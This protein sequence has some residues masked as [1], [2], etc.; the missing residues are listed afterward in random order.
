MKI[1]VIILVVYLIGLLAVGALFSKFNKNT[2]DY[3]RGGAKASWWLGGASMVLASISA[4]TF[5]GNASAAFDA[6][7]SLLVIYAANCSAFLVCALFLGARL[8]Q[9]RAHTVAD[10][11]RERFGTAAEQTT[12]ISGVLLAPFT[13]AVQLW[14]LSLFASVILDLPLTPTILAIGGIVVFY[15]TAGGR[16]AVMAT[17]F[18]QGVLL[19]GV[20]AI[21]FVLALNK[22]GGVDGFLSFFS[23]PRF[24]EDFS[25][26]KEPGAFPDDKFTWHWMVVIFFMQLYFQLGMWG[27][28]RFLSLKDGKEARKASL[29]A[30]TLV[31]FGVIIW[32]LPP[33]VSRFLYESEV[34]ALDV[35]SPSNYSY[36]YIARQ[37]LPNGM[38]GLMVAAMFA[39]TM[40]SMDTGLN[41][42]TGMIARNLLPWICKRFGKTLPVDSIGIRICKIITVILGIEIVALAFALSVQERFPLFD[43]YLMIASLVGIPLGFP[44]LAGLWIKRMPPWSFFLIFAGCLIPSLYSIYDETANGVKWSIQDRSMW[45]FI[46]GIAACIISRILYFTTGEKWRERTEAF[47]AQLRK[48]IDFEKE[49]GGANDDRQALILG[50]VCLAMGLGALSLIAM[51]NPL[52]GRLCFV[53]LSAFMA[54]VGALLIRLS[55]RTKENADLS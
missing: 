41:N 27:A 52:W 18:A 12:V 2:S 3:I 50:R 22:V 25:F 10:L 36:A 14:S 33:M 40:S 19:V 16:W 39:A 42:Q 5:T 49:V 34:M 1:E 31:G 28:H 9:S 7:P 13:A 46:Y 45:I 8:R 29:L 53:A 26:V 47:F 11:I 20:S 30:L 24:S 17:D 37:L 44:L 4:F 35:D 32:F 43:A 23:D 21:V 6:G 51:S 15:S 54:S 48:R 38:M 55:K